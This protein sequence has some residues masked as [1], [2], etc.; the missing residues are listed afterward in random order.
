[1]ASGTAA[2]SADGGR[3]LV[4]PDGSLRQL[5]KR[6]LSGAVRADEARALAVADVNRDSTEQG[7]SGVGEGK[8]VDVD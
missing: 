4:W 5:Q 3:T 8:V 2:Q 1:M 7:R 6:G